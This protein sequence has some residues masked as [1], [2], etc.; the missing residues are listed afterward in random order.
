MAVYWSPPRG[1]ASRYPGRLTVREKSNRL[2]IELDNNQMRAGKLFYG[3]AGP[4]VE[5]KLD[6]GDSASP[7]ATDS[8]LAVLARP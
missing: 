5:F 6:V 8:I 1:L 3:H 2:I 7:V 4:I